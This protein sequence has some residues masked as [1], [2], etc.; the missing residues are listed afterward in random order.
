MNITQ[1]AIEKLQS[2][3]LG[4]KEGKVLDS[5]FIKIEDAI[6]VLKDFE[7]EIIEQ[8]LQTNI[9]YAER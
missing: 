1:K 6:Q 5:G 4:Y 9:N 7:Q 2:L 8:F 3:E